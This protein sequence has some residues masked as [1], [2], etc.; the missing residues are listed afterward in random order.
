MSLN[1]RPEMTDLYTQL[2]E[3]WKQAGG[4]V[5]MNFSDIARPSKWG[6]WGALEFVGQA[7]SPKYNALI[8]FID[9]NS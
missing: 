2:L 9:R 8:N 6:S 4:T 3:A 5:F 1:R 7:R